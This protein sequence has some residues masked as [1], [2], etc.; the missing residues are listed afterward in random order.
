VLGFADAGYRRIGAER[1]VN[2]ARSAE[3]ARA[4]CTAVLAAEERE[5]LERAGAGLDDAGVARL[6][7]APGD[8]GGRA[9]TAC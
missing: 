5:E 1:E 8:D 9:D 7:H 4:L 3:R 6:V 2:E